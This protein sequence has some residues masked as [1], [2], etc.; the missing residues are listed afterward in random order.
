MKK[1]IIFFIL[2]EIAIAGTMRN[3]TQLESGE[4]YSYK[5]NN[6]ENIFYFY[7]SGTGNFYAKTTRQNVEIKTMFMKPTIAIYDAR[8][9]KICNNKFGE[10]E[11][12]CKLLNGKYFLQIDSHANSSQDLIMGEF[13][14]YSKDIPNKNPKITIKLK[15]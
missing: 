12:N 15:D 10:D 3:P 4:T 5:A 11:L 9:N 13:T 6:K 8:M 2:T 14:T 1:A 7:I